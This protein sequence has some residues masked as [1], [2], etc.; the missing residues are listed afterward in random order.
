MS[1]GSCNN[2][3]LCGVSVMVILVWVRECDFYYS[4]GSGWSFVG[5]LCMHL[6]NAQLDIV[7]GRWMG[8]LI[9]CLRDRDGPVNGYSAAFSTFYA[10]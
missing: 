4:L 5:I 8:D 7:T 3:Q 6:F 2:G 1:S 10:P 9:G